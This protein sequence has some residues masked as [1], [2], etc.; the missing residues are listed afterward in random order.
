MAQPRAWRLPL[1]LLPNSRAYDEAGNRTNQVD[2]LGRQTRFEYD[3]LGWRKPESFGYD[4]VGSLLY[5]TG[6]E[7]DPD[8]GM[9]YLRARYLNP[10]TGRFWTRDSQEGDNEDPLR[11]HGYIYCGDNPADNVDPSGHD[12]TS[13][14]G[15]LSI[16]ASLPSVTSG[17]GL[18]SA[19][20]P[21]T[22]RKWQVRNNSKSIAWSV[23]RFA[24]GFQY[25]ILDQFNHPLPGVLVTESVNATFYGQL[26]FPTRP[27]KT[28]SATTDSNG[29]IGDFHQWD[30]WAPGGFVQ[31][32]QTVI[33]GRWSANFVEI[34]WANGL[35]TGKTSATFK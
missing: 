25:V 12:L 11:M 9:Y 32:K 7:W 26:F 35:W 34:D 24:V 16:L 10:N 8:L 22:V 18:D 5:H 3:S 21:Q 2:A 15:G 20:R 31:T 19:P 17:A 6:E 1:G 23:W 13:L 30:F 33:V 27:P 4:L 14:L 28:G 29:S